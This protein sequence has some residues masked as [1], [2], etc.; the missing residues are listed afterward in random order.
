[1]D[2][3]S[4]LA[5]RVAY[6]LWVGPIPEGL[7]VRHFVCDNPP[8][9]NPAHLRV[10]THKDNMRDMAIKGRRKGINAGSEHGK[11]ILSES[12]VLDIRK[13]YAGGFC[14]QK[15]LGD[16]YGVSRH[17]INSVISR[18]NWRHI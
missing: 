10:G 12:D 16:T 13:K 5:P 3:K 2:Y 14:T 4:I 7:L 6:E 18:Q 8:C 15:T 1:M 17:T 9:I 11:A